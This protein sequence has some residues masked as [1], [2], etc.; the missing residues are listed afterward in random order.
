MEQTSE[1]RERM[2]ASQ[3]ITRELESSWRSS[4][5]NGVILKNEKMILDVFVSAPIMIDQMLY[6]L[7]LDGFS[8]KDAATR[9]KSVLGSFS[10]DFSMLPDIVLQDTQDQYRNFTL[11]EFS[12]Q[13]PHH[14]ARQSLIQ[15]DPSTFVSLV[16]KYYDVN[17]DVMRE[18]AGKKLRSK[19]RGTIYD[20]C[21][22]L[23]I[24]PTA[25]RRQF[26]NLKRI[27]GFLMERKREGRLRNI[28]ESL[29]QN[30]MLSKD[31]C[32]K[33]TRY[34]FLYY[35]RI[36]TTDKRLRSLS[37]QDFEY[38]AQCLMSQWTDD[39]VHLDL[40]NKF[41]DDVRD[42]RAYLLSDRLILESYRNL[43]I[44]Q[45]LR[46]GVDDKIAHHFTSKFNGLAKA[47]L[48][49]G[50]GIS[51]SS[52]FEDILEDMEEKVADVFIKLNMSQSEVDL[53]FK[54]LVQAF[55]PLLNTLSITRHR[56]RF[57]KS[58]HRFL[59]GIRLCVIHMHLVFGPPRGGLATSK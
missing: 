56:D 31:L 40:D 45:L 32:D 5:F 44:D 16:E 22:Q 33:Y 13:N 48:N 51:K 9:M 20:L 15:L 25:C 35:H 4:S 12:L 43:V 28:S 23:K 8:A 1:A 50:A 42:L 2:T 54:S 18:L 3:G 46:L 14:F 57:A 29:Q 38:F 34:F 37:A 52:E 55:D 10:M 53:V 39:A 21:A 59:E 49:I 47:L 19:L 41:K 30:F 7:W 26:D 27:Y 36:E 17:L 6:A 24:S 11:L 58:W